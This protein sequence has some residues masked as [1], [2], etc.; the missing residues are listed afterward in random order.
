MKYMILTYASQRDYDG[1]A[2]R[3]AM[4]S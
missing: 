2:G 3:P 4:P 1:M